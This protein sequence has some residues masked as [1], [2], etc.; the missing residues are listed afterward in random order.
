M[1]RR[2]PE[3]D[4]VRPV[5]KQ[6]TSCG[7]DRLM[8]HPALPRTASSR[9]CWML[10][11]A[12]TNRQGSMYLDSADQIS[13]C[14]SISLAQWLAHFSAVR[15]GLRHFVQ[16][17]ECDHIGVCFRQTGRLDLDT[18]REEFDTIR[19]PWRASPR[20]HGERTRAR[21]LPFFRGRLRIAV[22]VAEDNR[23]CRCDRCGTKITGICS[24]ASSGR[25]RMAS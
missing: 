18:P 14:R 16:G 13:N 11:L 1:S 20:G 25:W 10:L 7:G 5:A 9:C 15:E 12:T 2:G 17:G 24:R 21:C 6:R 8:A 3:L 19:R 23:L 22:Q 4:D